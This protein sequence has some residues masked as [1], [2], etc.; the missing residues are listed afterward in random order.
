MRVLVGA[1]GNNTHHLANVPRWDS[2]RLVDQAALDSRTLTQP[3]RA[4]RGTAS[5]SRELSELHTELRQRSL[6]ILF[7]T[8]CVFNTVYVAWCGFDYLI[9]PRHFDYFL[10]LRL[11]AAAINTALVV[12]VHNRRLS[13]FTW[14]AFWLW[15]F[16]KGVFLALMLRVVDESSYVPYVVGFTLIIYAAGLLPYWPPRWALSII[17]VLM[18]LSLF[19]R[20]GLIGRDAVASIF[21]LLS[22]AGLALI[23][24]YFKYSLAGSDFLTRRALSGLARREHDARVELDRSGGALRS[25]LEQLKELDRLKSQFFANISHELRTPLTLILTPLENM[26]PELGR[27]SCWYCANHQKSVTSA[28]M[29]ASA[30]RSKRS[31]MSGSPLSWI[32]L[33]VTT[34]QSI[35]PSSARTS[36]GTSA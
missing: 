23:S 6:P 15:L 36:S 26:R 29:R 4:R 1:H 16:V 31:G 25:A 7:G 9:E 12:A 19:S 30:R 34:V 2:E 18:A 17:C 5:S 35:L 11:T 8:A 24:V 32:A 28:R 21:I 27:G 3:A 13:R 10:G 22:A 14:E 20:P 33:S